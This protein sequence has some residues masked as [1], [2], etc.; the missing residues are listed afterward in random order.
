M[1]SPVVRRMDGEEEVGDIRRLQ[2][3]AIDHRLKSAFLIIA[4]WAKTLDTEWDRLSPEQRR[5]G[6]SAIRGRAETMVSH[7]ESLLAQLDHHAVLPTP[8]ETADLA[9]MCRATVEAYDASTSH[10]V[11]YIGLD[12]MLV[13]ASED[14][15]DQILGQLLENALKYSPA[16]S[17]IDVRVHDTP[18][19]ALLL[20]RDEGCGIPRDVDIFGAYTRG[21]TD[22]SGSGVG[23][24]VVAEVVRSLGGSVDARRLP[25]RGSQFAVTLPKL[26]A[27]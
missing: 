8:T 25:G 3:A 14:D 13:A 4:G 2:L 20:V 1:T 12:R 19:G 22:T 5:F 7:A 24:Y 6:I 21:D 18:D 16:T 26:A 10:A 17:I 15:L 9:A 11:R 23:L 27:S